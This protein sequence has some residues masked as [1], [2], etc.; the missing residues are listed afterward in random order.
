MREFGLEQLAAHGEEAETRERHATWIL[1]LT[2]EAAPQLFRAEQQTWRRRLE[3]ER[4]NIRA[5]LAWFVQIGD[6]ERAQRLAGSLLWFGI[7]SGALRETHAWLGRAL[8]I[9]GESSAAARGW[10]LVTAAVVT[11]FLGDYDQAWSLAE[12]GQAV[13]YAGGFARGV[14]VAK[15]TFAECAWMQGDL[16]TAIVLGEEAISLLRQV[17]DPAWLAIPLADMGVVAL[18]AGDRARGDTWSGESLAINRALGNHWFI[19]AHRSDLGLVAHSRGD[20]KEAARHYAESVRL[21]VE[22]EDRWY[23]ASPLS[24][25]AA[26][27]VET[28]DPEIA[29][30]LLGAAAGLR[31]AS[32]FTILAS[33]QERDKRTAAAARRAL[34]DVRYGQALTVGRALPLDRVAED[35]IACVGVANLLDS[36]DAQPSPRSSSNP[37]G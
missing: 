22:A 24:G 28:G 37:Q 15:M 7:V 27:A 34:G 6:G 14:A 9:Q 10:A 32:G 17:G 16:A 19:A 26:I 2:E 29:A 21:F 5:A 36:L 11:W 30:R 25:L 1:A 35:A 8:A 18:L 20:L 3:A 13:S 33:E 12:K 31:E 23:I 4:A